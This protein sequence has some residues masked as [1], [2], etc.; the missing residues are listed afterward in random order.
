MKRAILAAGAALLVAWSV[1]PF[2][3]SVVTAVKP[4]AEVFRTPPT[5]LPESLSFE[6]FVSI[7][8]RR[9]FARYLANSLV[10]AIGSTV[11]ALTA[12]AAAAY[13]LT[14]LRLRGAESIQRAF[15]VFALFP[16]AVFLVPL[17][18]AAR[19]FGFVNSYAGLIL[20]HAA[21]NL[22]FAIWALAS[23]FRELPIEIEEAARVDGF[24]R[25]QILARIVAPLSAPALAATAIL[26]FIFSWNEFVIALTFMQRDAMRTVPVGISMLSGVT[27]FE[28]PWDQISAAI[29]MTTLPIVAAVL[30]FQ[31]WI[32]SGL[33]AGAVKG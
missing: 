15:L 2:L 32:L 5:Y 9:P 23:F 31:R 19:T 21:L 27:V 18:S 22:P 26:V 29:V 28:V 7:F 4:T 25:F 6:S 11:V 17:F 10:V 33:T 24:S 14:R 13:A 1:G 12:G 3:W 16:P 30:V 8:E 20:A